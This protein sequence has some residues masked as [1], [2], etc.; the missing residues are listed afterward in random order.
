MLP[1][2]LQGVWSPV[3]HRLTLDDKAAGAD[4]N[5]S[6]AERMAV[7]HGTYVRQ[8]YFAVHMGAL[9]SPTE[10][11]AATVGGHRPPRTPPTAPTRAGP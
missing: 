10:V 8:R 4:G 6:D 2:D 1:A 3:G 7:P 11:A 5:A 9:Q